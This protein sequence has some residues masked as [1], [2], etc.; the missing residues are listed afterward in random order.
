MAMAE[1][2]RKIW[3]ETYCKGN[4][5]ATDKEM[6]SYAIS[7]TDDPERVAER[8][9]LIEASDHSD[10]TYYHIVRASGQPIG[11]VYGYKNDAHQELFALY[12]AKEFHRKGVATQLTTDLFRW[13]DPQRPVELGVVEDNI[14]AQQ[15]Y[16]TLGFNPIP[17][18]RVAFQGS[19]HVHEIRMIRQP[20]KEQA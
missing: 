20:Q 19:E 14:E 11:M 5:I 4:N 6:L 16:E 8:A 2:Q 7:M 1:M 12:V 13:F 10:S 9:R 18:S 17:D 15:F 3:I